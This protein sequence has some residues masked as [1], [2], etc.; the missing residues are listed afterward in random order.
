MRTLDRY[1]TYVRQPLESGAD[2]LAVGAGLPLDLPARAVR[3]PWLD[4]YLRL[5]ERMPKAAHVK[6]H[7]TMWFD[8][9]AQCGLRDGKA[10][11]GPFCID[12]VL[13][14]AL[15]GDVRK[16]L[17]FRGAGQPLAA[18]EPEVQAA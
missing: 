18:N 4:K 17:F 3:M 10:A 2:A 14:H 6:A 1:E 7:C 15:G 5:Q 16:G 12:K 8:C 9:L 11:W 13:G